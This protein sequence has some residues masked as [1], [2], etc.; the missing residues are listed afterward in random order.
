MTVQQNINNAIQYLVMDFMRYP[1]KY[2]TESDI[3]CF[4]FTELMKIKKFSKLQNTSD[5]SKSTSVHTEVRWYGD[6]GKLKYLSDIVIINPAQ[7]RTKDGYFKLPSKSYA[8][9]YPLTIIEIKL[10][11]IN[12]GTDNIFIKKVSKDKKKNIKSNIENS[13]E[14]KVFYE[15]PSFETIIDSTLKKPKSGNIT[16]N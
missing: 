9:N 5:N 3:K 6:S 15:Y 4:L 10:R 8:F 1:N 14:I 7:L 2:L 13:N 12:G 16:A 11:R